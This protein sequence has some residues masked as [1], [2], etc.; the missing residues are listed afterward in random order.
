MN[1]VGTAAA[2]VAPAGAW[3]CAVDIESTKAAATIAILFI[4]STW[5]VQAC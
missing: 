4:T 5:A 3:A 2:D 1:V